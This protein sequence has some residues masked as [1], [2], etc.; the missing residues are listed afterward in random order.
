EV[1]DLDGDL[2]GALRDLFDQALGLDAVLRRAEGGGEHDQLD[3]AGQLGQ[4]APDRLPV[5]LGQDCHGSAPLRFTPS[6]Y[7]CA[8]RP[9]P[10]PGGPP[11]RARGGGGGGRPPPRRA[12]GPCVRGG[13]ARGGGGGG[14][15]PVPPGARP[16][17]GGG[18]PPAPGGAWR[19]PWRSART[20]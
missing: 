4:L 9:R 6:L 1:Q 11:A 10:T 2:V 17:G 20:T 13:G 14:C 15:C 16:R 8:R 19:S 7:A 3:R 12:G 5:P 18:A